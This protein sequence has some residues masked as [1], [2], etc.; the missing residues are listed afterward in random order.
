[1]IYKNLTYVNDVLYCNYGISKN[2][3]GNWSGGSIIHVC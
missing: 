1:M 3:N 2:K